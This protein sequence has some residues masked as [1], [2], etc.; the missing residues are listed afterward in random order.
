MSDDDI[1]IVDVVELSDSDDEILV[2]EPGPAVVIESLA[3]G[4]DSDAQ[5][6]RIVVV[7]SNSPSSARTAACTVAIESLA[8]GDDANSG[9]AP[10]AFLDPLKLRENQQAKKKRQKEK[11]EQE[12][13]GKRS[14]YH[15]LN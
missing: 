13:G 1:L 8:D 4:D 7:E 14:K 12:K 15:N 5:S 3:D 2:G 11:E 10:V 6:S 9:P